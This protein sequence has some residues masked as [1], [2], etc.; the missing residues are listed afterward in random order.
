MGVEN[1]HIYNQFVVRVPQRDALRHFLQE[2]G[3]GSEIY[4]PLP[5]HLQPCF[6][7]LGYSE[8]DFP[9]SER[10]AKETLALPIY[11]ELTGEQQE[12]VVE[13]IAQFYARS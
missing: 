3:I 4:Y 6:A 7:S 9:E 5:L 1:H 13:K 11:P 10:A 8:G 12:Y 2:N